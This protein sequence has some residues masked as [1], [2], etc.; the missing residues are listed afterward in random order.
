MKYSILLTNNTPE[1]RERLSQQF[2][3]CP[4]CEFKDAKWLNCFPDDNS[5]HGLGYALEDTMPDS[6]PAKV[7]RWCIEDALA[8]G[9]TVILTPSV[10]EFLSLIKQYGK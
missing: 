5:V 4:C 10:D 1:I 6:T 2:S 3:L 7:F 9:D 8:H